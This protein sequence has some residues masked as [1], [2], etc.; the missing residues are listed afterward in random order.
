MRLLIVG[1]GASYAECK[2]AGLQDS[3]CMP[4]MKHLSRKLWSEFSPTPFLEKFLEEIGTP[5]PW[6]NPIE[7]FHELELKTPNLIEKF[8]AY[9]WAHRDEFHT[10][11]SRCWDDLMHHG[12]LN[13]LIHILVT[14]LLANN[15]ANKLPL[16]ESVTRLLEPDDLVL[17]LNYD[18]I[19]DVALKN[20]GKE[21]VY[22]PNARQPGRIWAF[23]PHGSFH[24]AVNEEKKSFYFSQVEFMGSAQ[25]SDG[26]RTYLGFIP[27]RFK[28]SFSQ[29]PHAEMII[30]PLLKF[31]PDIISFWGVGSPESDADL[32]EVYNSLCSTAS[33]IEYVNP[34][35]EDAL[36]FEML[37][38]RKITH[39]KSVGQWLKTKEPASCDAGST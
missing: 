33:R 9:A 15:P 39:L 2:A 28:K 10:Q 13:P 26:A 4:L 7:V 29:H 37:L 12:L 5:G 27:P 23:K 21:A 1:A 18:L 17:N 25:P 35:E 24:L 22:S 30:A 31:K 8:F 14:G 16:S 19:F 38:G 3:Q 32:F 36:R 11:Y 20:A 34:S 6:K